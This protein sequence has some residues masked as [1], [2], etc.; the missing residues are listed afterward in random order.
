MTKIYQT[1]GMF[2]NIFIDDEYKKRKKTTC[3]W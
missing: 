3:G 2:A 1:A